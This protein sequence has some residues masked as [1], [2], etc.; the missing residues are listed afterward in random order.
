MCIKDPINKTCWK[1]GNDLS[2]EAPKIKLWN[3]TKKTHFPV[4][5]K[6]FRRPW[7]K[8]KI[9][10]CQFQNLGPLGYQ[11]WVVIPR[12]VKKPKSLHP[13]AQLGLVFYFWNQKLQMIWTGPQV[14][15][16]Y[17]TSKSHGNRSV[18]PL[19]GESSCGADMSVCSF[20]T[21][22][23]RSFYFP[24]IAIPWTARSRSS[25]QKN[26]GRAAWHLCQ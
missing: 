1:N 26:A 10:F 6:N 4:F 11:G 7:M 20:C 8:L 5:A 22:D 14:V 17:W 13:T 18:N 23:W 16:A 25:F 15:T 2:N 21:R 24:E 9:F 3:P 19:C 12:N